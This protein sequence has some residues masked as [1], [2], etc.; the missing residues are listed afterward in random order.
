MCSG[1]TDQTPDGTVYSVLE[2][3]G[4]DQ[5]SFYYRGIVYYVSVS[6]VC[7]YCNDRAHFSNQLFYRN[8][9][10]TTHLRLFA[11]IKL[12]LYVLQES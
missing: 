4:L 6:A 12:K 2:R 3:T 7:G 5:E 11:T 10:L 1:G 8:V 9:L